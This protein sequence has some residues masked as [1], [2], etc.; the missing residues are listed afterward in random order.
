MITTLIFDWGDTLMRDFPE[1]SGP[2]YTWK[3][4]EWIPGAKNVLEAV[5]FNYEMVVATNAGESNTEAM[6]KALERVG[7]EAYFDA[8]YSSKDLGVR[9][10]D[11][12]F[13]L[14]ICEKLNRKPD[15]CVMIGN[16][17]E[18][19]IV[20]AKQAGLKTIFFNENNAGI[21]ADQADYVIF[22]MEDLVDVV[23]KF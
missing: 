14:T 17:Y 15:Q 19:D 6:I 23:E 8:F 10:P 13:F 20:G 4:V 12:E 3:H 21:I 16:N 2:M 11:P 7:A 22:N 18:K 9:K 5:F 1:K